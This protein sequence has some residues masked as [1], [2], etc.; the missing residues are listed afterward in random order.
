M[1]KRIGLVG[2]AVVLTLL[3]SA[4]GNEETG[5][6]ESGAGSFFGS[7]EHGEHRCYG[8]ERSGIG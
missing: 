8:G 6:E 7:R 3:M 5:G 2:L 1:R 4:C